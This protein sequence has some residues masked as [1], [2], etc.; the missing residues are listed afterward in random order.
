MYVS[1]YWQFIFY[2]NANVNVIFQTV[3]SCVFTQQMSF[4]IPRNICKSL[5]VYTE[6]ED[7]QNIA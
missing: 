6:I 3:I 4:L 2:A 7:T 1:M 5:H